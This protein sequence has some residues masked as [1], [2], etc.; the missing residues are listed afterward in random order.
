M[1]Q[2]VSLQ[3]VKPEPWRNGRGR[4][5]ELCVWPGSGESG[6]EAAWQLRI[7]V[8]QIDRDGPFSA[9]PGVQRWFAVLQGNG[10]NLSF[11]DQV[12]RL[13]SQSEAFCFD[14]ALAP[15][16]SLVD[17]PTLDLNLMLRADAGQ[18]SMQRVQPAIA[19]ASSAPLRAIFSLD[20]LT[21]WADGTAASSL[22]AATLALDRQCK[23]TPWRVQAQG[24]QLRAWWMHFT[25]HRR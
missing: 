25:P 11:G 12:Q 5:Q 21:L 20:P 24:P 8:A 15:G 6:S 2:R 16:C 7:S 1:M 10:V 17:G 19:F 18:G 14:G 9:F 3:D 23:P 22:P 13:N 4:T